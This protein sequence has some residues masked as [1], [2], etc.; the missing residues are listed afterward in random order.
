M[1]VI[2]LSPNSIAVIAPAYRP[3]PGA[4]QPA[5]GP[6]VDVALGLQFGDAYHAAL[7]GLDE[8]RQQV[9]ER[10]L[11]RL[12]GVAAG[13]E[14]QSGLGEFADMAGKIGRGLRGLERL[15]RGAVHHQSNRHFVRP[16][17]AVVVVAD[18]AEHEG[19]LVEVGEVVDD[20]GLVGRRIGLGLGATRAARG[21]DE[22]GGAGQHGGEQVASVHGVLLHLRRMAAS[23]LRSVMSERQSSRLARSSLKMRSSAPPSRLRPSSAGLL[24]CQMRMLSRRTSMALSPCASSTEMPPPSQSTPQPR[25][26]LSADIS[27]ALGWPQSPLESKLPRRSRKLTPRRKE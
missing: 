23:S 8:T 19:D 20:L 26:I 25:C 15:E 22:A 24:F 16:A 27:K 2:V 9:G 12:H 3:P 18:I 10:D 1:A 13:G 4:K 21:G 7:V 11:L 14:R 5:S 6:Q 17:G